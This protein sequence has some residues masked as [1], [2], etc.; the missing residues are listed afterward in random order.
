MKPVSYKNSWSEQDWKFIV[1][2]AK[3]AREDVP[4][5]RRMGAN[6]VRRWAKRA[7]E[8][9]RQEQQLRTL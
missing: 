7:I 6:A 9:A 5:L 1:Q 2:D 4:M 3:C 8:M